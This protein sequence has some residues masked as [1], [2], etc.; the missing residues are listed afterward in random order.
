MKGKKHESEIKV[1]RRSNNSGVCDYNLSCSWV[2]RITAGHFALG[3][4]KANSARHDSLRPY[5][6]KWLV[7]GGS[8]T[9]EF[10]IIL[11]AVLM[12]LLLALSVLSFSLARVK[13]VE[14]AGAGARA[15]ARGESVQ[16][17]E[18]MLTEANLKAKPEVI[19]ENFLVCL[20]LTTKQE[21]FQ[22]GILSFTEQACS[23]R[24]GL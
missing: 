20:K 11:P 12:I 5:K 16:I 13:V 6:S 1:R 3:R 10:A 22:L 23:R 2:C 8:V 19:T 7:D 15:L 14:L 24:A 18:Q 4:S 21:I 17:V 9:A